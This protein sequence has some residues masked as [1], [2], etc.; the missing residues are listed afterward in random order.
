MI[1]E[2]SKNCFLHN[3]RAS[4]VYRGVEIYLPD[5]L[6][7]AFFLSEENSAYVIFYFFRG[8][9]SSSNGVSLVEA[10]SDASLR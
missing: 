6:F 5:A 10:I 3:K 4:G 2:N 7:N 8:G 9:N 1:C